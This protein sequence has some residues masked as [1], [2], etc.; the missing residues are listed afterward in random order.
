MHQLATHAKITEELCMAA[1]HGVNP[2]LKLIELA[3]AG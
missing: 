2:F 1:L 3:M